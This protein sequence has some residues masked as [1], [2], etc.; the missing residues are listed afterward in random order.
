MEQQEFEKKVQEKKNERLAFA[1]KMN[2][3]ESFTYLTTDM[4]G[5]EITPHFRRELSAYRDK[6]Q[7]VKGEYWNDETFRNEV[8]KADFHYVAA[9]PSKDLTEELVEKLIEV[10]PK[11]FVCVPE[12]K[13]T[14]NL[15]VKVLNQDQDL[16]VFLPEWMIGKI[17]FQTWLFLT[18]PVANKAIEGII[19]SK[20]MDVL[21]SQQKQIIEHIF[22]KY[23]K[24][25]TIFKNNL[26]F[27]AQ[28]EVEKMESDDLW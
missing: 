20:Y 18:S 1:N 8:I 2:R 27:Y 11:I 3:E 10:N 12:H 28:K 6:V 13:I 14:E 7:Y 24:E 5:N 22:Y 9:I 16:V 23:G 17:N 26:Q 21:V 19:N 15:V 4:V 25:F